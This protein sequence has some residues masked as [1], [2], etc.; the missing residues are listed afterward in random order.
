VVEYL[1][2]DSTSKSV[3]SAMLYKKKILGDIRFPRMTLSMHFRDISS[4]MGHNDSFLG[5]RE[6]NVPSKLMSAVRYVQSKNG[7]YKTERQSRRLQTLQA[8]SPRWR[9]NWLKLK[10]GR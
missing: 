9:C 8:R 6:A 4:L 5:R 7:V 3:T 2:F 10:S 1:T